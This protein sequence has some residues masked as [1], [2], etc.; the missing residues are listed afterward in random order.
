MDT[1][2][3]DNWAESQRLKLEQ[4]GV[5]LDISKMEKYFTFTTMDDK[6]KQTELNTKAIVKDL[7]MDELKIEEMN[8]MLETL[9]EM[10]QADLAIKIQQI[11]L[12]GALQERF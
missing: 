2:T 8:I 4:A 12:G 3:K 11:I 9:P 6:I 1:I 5:N 10:N 7:E